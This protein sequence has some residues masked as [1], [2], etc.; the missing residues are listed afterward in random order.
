MQ[1][2][3]ILPVLGAVMLAAMPLG[4]CVLVVGN[5]LDDDRRSWRDE[6][7]PRMIGVTMG[8]VDGALASQLAGVDADRSTLILGVI[9]DMPAERAGVREHDIVVQIDGSD[10]A[11]PDDLGRA[12]RRKGP[13][14]EIRLRVL[15]AGA[16]VDLTIVMDDRKKWAD[17][18]S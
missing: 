12:I 7:S 11:S 4:G 5:D 13:G 17:I 2:Y 3:G 9:G 18:G 15:R 16:P 8:P 6:E 14:E 1:R 10:E